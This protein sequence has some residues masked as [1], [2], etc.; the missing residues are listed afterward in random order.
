[1]NNISEMSSACARRRSAGKRPVPDDG[2]TTGRRL[3]TYRMNRRSSHTGDGLPL[4]V[5]RDPIGDR[6]SF[7]RMMVRVNRRSLM[8]LS[9]LIAG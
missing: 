7:G 1:M 8:T 6:L 5:L 2:L 9:C 3:I 4:A